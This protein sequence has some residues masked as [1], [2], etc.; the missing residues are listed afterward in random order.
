MP[1]CWEYP[2]FCQW[3]LM[4]H[5][6]AFAEFDAAE[7]KQQCRMLR[8]ADYTANKWSVPSLRMGTF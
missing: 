2:Y 4:F 1:D 8:Q 7:A 3:D 6:V 5:A